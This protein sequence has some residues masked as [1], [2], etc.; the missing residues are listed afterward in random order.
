[1]EKLENAR[2]F[3]EE[4]IEELEVTKIDSERWAKFDKA[5]RNLGRAAIDDSVTEDEWRDAIKAAFDLKPNNL[6]EANNNG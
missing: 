5:C 1:M 6:D 3:F 2:L 4:L